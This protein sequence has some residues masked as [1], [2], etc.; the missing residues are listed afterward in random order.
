VTASDTALHAIET[1]VVTAINQQVRSVNT[2]LGDYLATAVDDNPPLTATELLS[3]SEVH[4]NIT[5]TLSTA[6]TTVAARVSTGHG[7]AVALAVLLVAAALRQD[8]TQPRDLGGYLPAVL[9]DITAAFGATLLGIHDGIRLGYDGIT[10]GPRA[11]RARR[12]AARAAVGKATGRLGV[13]VR[14]AGS[15]AVHRG[16]SDAQ[17]TLYAEVAA[18]HPGM[19]IT[20]RWQVTSANPCP[21]CAALDGT[22]LPLEAV[23]D[24]AATTDPN[25][26]PPGVYRDLLVP[27]RHPNCRCR[28]TY[29]AS[30]TV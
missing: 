3:R 11:R 22:V 9:G 27:P 2:Q 6:Q 28:L 13:R 12:I 15:V 21:A 7:A 14:A 29:Q 20:K 17:A 4:Q 10:G 26:S 19:V 30:N 23:F 18:T 8:P 24:A 1:R 25:T 16:F 5:S